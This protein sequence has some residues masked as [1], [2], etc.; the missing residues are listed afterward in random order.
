MEMVL[1]E[2]F[3]SNLISNDCYEQYDDIKVITDTLKAQNIDYYLFDCSFG[4]KVFSTMLILMDEF[5]R[6]KTNFAA[7][8]SFPVAVERCFTEIFQSYDI[9]DT[10]SLLW[11]S[12][13]TSA[14]NP[15][16]LRD[17]VSL[18]NYTI[19]QRHYDACL[20][21]PTQ[22]ATKNASTVQDFIDHLTSAPDLPIKN[23][24][25]R[26]ISFLGFTTVQLITLPVPIFY[27]PLNIYPSLRSRNELLEGKYLITE[28]NIGPIFTNFTRCHTFN[29]K[30][31][32]NINDVLVIAILAALNGSDYI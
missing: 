13:K 26:E 31:R 15:V 18:G 10:K 32:H 9:N 12:G 14:N 29:D 20:S 22:V 16:N 24:L 1:F 4:G 11:E 8:S 6:Y 2:G 27:M 3:V 17:A 25:Y 23:V 5:G 19:T 7:S 30:L 28:E 21:E